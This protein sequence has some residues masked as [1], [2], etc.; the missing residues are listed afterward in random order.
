MQTRAQIWS[1]GRGGGVEQ[2]GAFPSFIFQGGLVLK[3]LMG[4]KDSL[5]GACLIPLNWQ[6]YLLITI[7]IFN[8]ASSFKIFQIMLLKEGGGRGESR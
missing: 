8:V 1:A 2:F 4:G 7:I 6:N 5:N 3:N